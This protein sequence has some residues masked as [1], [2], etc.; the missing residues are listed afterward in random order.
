MTESLRA[1]VQKRLVFKV[2]VFESPYSALLDED[3]DENFVKG[4]RFQNAKVVADVTSLIVKLRE[5][6]QSEHHDH[7]CADQDDK[8]GPDETCECGAVV[9]QRARVFF[10]EWLEGETK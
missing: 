2:P 8:F 3:Y 7:D 1:R 6:M 4:A 10:N 5:A 9:A